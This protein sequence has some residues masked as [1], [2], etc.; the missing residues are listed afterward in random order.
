MP[1]MAVVAINI[2]NVYKKKFQNQKAYDFET[3]HVALGRLYK[4]CISHDPGITLI[5]LWQSQLRSPTHW[6]WEKC[7]LM[8]ANLLGMGKWIKDFC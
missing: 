2:K 8:A 6:N 7:H 4:I 3:W 5:Y 1:K